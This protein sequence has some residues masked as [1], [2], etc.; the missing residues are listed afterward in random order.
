MIDKTH[1]LY[2]FFDKAGDLLYVGISN[3]P[4]RRWAQHE[5]DKPWWHE[6]HHVEIE[7]YPDRAAVLV[8]EAEAI[9]AENP[10]Y[11][12]ALALKNEPVVEQLTQTVSCSACSKPARAFYVRQDDIWPHMQLQRKLKDSSV[13]LKE[14]CFSYSALL[15]MPMPARWRFCCDEH[16]P[17]ET[18]VFYW[19]P[20]GTHSRTEAADAIRHLAEKEWVGENTFWGSLVLRLLAPDQPVG[21][22]ATKGEAS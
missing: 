21:W 19:Y 17:E 6:V 15:E 14:K 16:A 4:G 22:T 1:A 20:Y 2:R 13:P 12:V 11:N 8:A 7:R 10:R 5:R 18:E 9:R 3:N